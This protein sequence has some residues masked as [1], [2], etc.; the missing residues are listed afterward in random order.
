MNF[1]LV[2]YKIPLLVWAHPLSLFLF[3]RLYFF[4]H[5]LS[6]IPEWFEAQFF[7]LK[8]VFLVIKCCQ[9]MKNE[10]V[11]IASAHHLLG[12]QWPQIEEGEE[13]SL[14]PSSSAIM[15]AEG[16][17]ET[18]LLFYQTAQ[19]NLTDTV[20]SC[21][22]EEVSLHDSSYTG[23]CKG[24]CVSCYVA[25]HVTSKLKLNVSSCSSLIWKIYKYVCRHW[26][27][28]DLC[29]GPVMV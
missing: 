28:W 20:R 10:S 19:R 7:A 22:M 4:L 25:V 17:F 16:F 2:H 29:L 13:R 24:V 9:V 21:K 18:L 6:S 5:F 8:N 12:S 15:E 3:L 1:L 14:V 23:Y 26:S 27:L 11:V